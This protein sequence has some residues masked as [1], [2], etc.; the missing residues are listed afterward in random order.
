MSG[1]RGARVPAGRGRARS[2]GGWAG[3][4]ARPWEG[5]GGGAGP[6]PSAR[7]GGGGRAR[8]PALFH[9]RCQRPPPRLPP[10]ADRTGGARATACPDSGAR[11]LRLR[12][13]G[14][15]GAPGPQG[16]IAQ[17]AGA[18]VPGDALAGLGGP[19]VCP[20]QAV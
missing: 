19:Q 4:R 15:G 7:A 8:R 6:G 14:R 16:V 17:G 9:F 2:P 10:A 1:G 11:R 3:A 20:L 13:R 5:R 18:Q 12:G